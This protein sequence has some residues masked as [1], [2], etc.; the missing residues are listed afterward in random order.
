MSC[1]V[2]PQLGGTPSRRAVLSTGLGSSGADRCYLD[3][4]IE[5]QLGSKVQR[6]GLSAARLCNPH[7]ASYLNDLSVVKIPDC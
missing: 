4:S 2:R 3:P 1:S 5:A 6:L 7:S